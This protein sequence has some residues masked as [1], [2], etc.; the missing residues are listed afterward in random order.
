MP[1]PVKFFYDLLSTHSRALYMFFEA[2]K[3][4]YDPIPVTKD[5]I[6]I[7]ARAISDDPRADLEPY[8]TQILSPEAPKPAAT[9]AEGEIFENTQENTVSTILYQLYFTIPA[10]VSCNHRQHDFETS[11][12]PG[13]LHLAC[14]PL[15]ELDYDESIARAQRIFKDIYPE[16]EFLPRAPDPEQIIIGDEEDQQQPGAGAGP[17]QQP[18][19]EEPKDKVESG[20]ECRESESQSSS[21]PVTPSGGVPSE[22]ALEAKEDEVASVEKAEECVEQK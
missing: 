19:K 21:V 14:G 2:T 11:K 3:I 4:P 22:N 8:V 7:T 13:N 20:R 1:R 9:P 5:L 18:E 15:L 6:H 16:E 10:C 12:L 17:G